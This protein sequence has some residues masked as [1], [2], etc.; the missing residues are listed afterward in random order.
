MNKSIIIGI[1][2]LV[3]AIIL[4]PF[5]ENELADFLGGISAGVGIGFL[6]KAFFFQQTRC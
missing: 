4:F 3:I 6:T 1:V 2:M 5:M